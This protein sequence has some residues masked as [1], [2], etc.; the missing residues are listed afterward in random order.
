MR[1][2]FRPPA[3]DAAGLLTLPWQ[4]PLEEWEDERLLEM[5]HRGI[6]RHVVR[7]VE[8]SGQ[9]FALKEIDERLARR[10]YRLLGRLQEM[11]MPAVTAVGVCVER[12]SYRGT[13][14]DA[15]LVTRFLD[16]S[17]SYRYL[18]SNRYATFPEG[19]LIDAMVELLVR[20][21][22]AGL[23]WGDCS[24]SN[25]L[26]RPDAGSIEAYFVD[27]ET[28]ELHPTLSDGQREYD[29][30]LAAERVGGELL[31]LQAGGLLPEHV[32]PIEVAASLTERYHALWD[33]LTREEPIDPADQRYQ[34]TKRV[35]RLNEL[36]FDVDEL[37]LVSTP[38]GARLKVR[39]KVG[40]SDRHRTRLFALTGLD[41]SDNQARRLLNDIVAYRGYLEQKEGRSIPETVAAHRWRIEIFD[42]VLGLV[43]PELRGRLAPAEIFHEVLEHRWFL[44]EQ[45]G[46]GV[47]TTT[48]ARS[49]VENVLPKLPQTLTPVATTHSAGDG[50]SAG[51]A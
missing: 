33:E 27:A 51:D 20:L 42:K 11:G 23:L 5:P 1:F 24:L 3:A 6:S 39:T 15:I 17:M 34:V 19:K 13:P 29:I 41:V 26:F 4:E 30:R 40:V 36:G 7:F 28:A 45:A 12:G 8:D 32:D 37:E 38:E 47:S 14:L 22:L 25:T 31:D 48:A 49:Y 50:A 9:I 10:E 18:F 46:R 2:I 44:S 16:F 43:P 35:E 21:H